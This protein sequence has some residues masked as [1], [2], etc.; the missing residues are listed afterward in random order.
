[1]NCCYILFSPSLDKFYTG[2]TQDTLE[3]RIL[4][5]NQHLH[6]S[7]RFTAK[8]S[9]WELFLQLGAESFAHARRMEL[10]IKK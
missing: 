7:H 4:K 5:H 9:D 6:G 2:I 1:M 8:A 3:S 10:K